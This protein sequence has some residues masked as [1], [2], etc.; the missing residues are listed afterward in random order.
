MEIAMVEV[1]QSTIQEFAD[2]HG[3]V[4]EVRERRK[5]IGDNSRY[6][7]MFKDAEVSEPGVLVGAH[8]NGA[9]PG[10]AIADYADRIS[11]KRLVIG[12]YGE[13]RREL[14]VPRLIPKS[15][16]QIPKWTT[17]HNLSIATR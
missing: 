5:P 10:E 13:A 7:A 8:G 6:Y 17:G 3:L 1:P 4:M 15:A 9:S 14:D 2:A 11:L 12:A 16:N